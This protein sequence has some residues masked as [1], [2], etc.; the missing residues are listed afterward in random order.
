[1]QKDRHGFLFPIINSVICVECGKCERTCP[2]VNPAE[3]QFLAECYAARCK[4]L[5]LRKQSSSGGIFGLLAL[6]VLRENGVVYGCA[7]S[8]E[9]TAEHIRIE[10]PEDLIKLQRSKYMQSNIGK[11]L[12][13][14]LEDLNAGRSVLFSGTPCQIAGLNSFLQKQKFSNLLTVEVICHGAPAPSSFE[15]YKNE[16]ENIYQK[17]MVDYIF[18]TKKAPCIDSYTSPTAVFADGG[19]IDL[20][21]LYSDYFFRAFLNNLNLRESCY[22][23]QAKNGKS[24]ADITLGDFWGLPGKYNMLNDGYGVS[25]VMLH[26]NLAKKHWNTIAEF[27]D[28]LPVTQDEITENNKAY[29]SS[30]K[31]PH[32]RWIFMFCYKF[33]FKFAL[34]MTFL[35]VKILRKLTFFRRN[36]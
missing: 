22:R 15:K 33:G 8:D 31:T 3:E 4:D 26:T 34:R 7:L 24:H 10:N 25:A 19:Q 9:L 18:R 1:M 11:T 14:C 35:F 23:C 12:T 5:D 13:S 20:P 17:Q 2:V 21:G 32:G 16:L 30:Y 29:Y 27:L 28:F 6:N 36:K